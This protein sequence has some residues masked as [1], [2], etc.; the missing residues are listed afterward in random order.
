MRKPFDIEE[1]EETSEEH[2]APVIDLAEYRKQKTYNEFWS[3]PCWTE[4][5]GI[6]G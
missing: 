4:E 1:V 5:P 6:L 3:D 2:L